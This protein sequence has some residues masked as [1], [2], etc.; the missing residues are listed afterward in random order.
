MFIQTL[1]P[2][3]YDVLMKPKIEELLLQIMN[4]I[5]QSKK[6]WLRKNERIDDNI[7]EDD[8]NEDED[9]LQKICFC[10][11]IICVI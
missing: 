6:K 10:L 8:D 7:K 9:I 3:K 1:P 2:E 5:K 11:K 4:T